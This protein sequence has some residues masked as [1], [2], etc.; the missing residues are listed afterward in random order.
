M[1]KQITFTKDAWDEFLYWQETDK[2]TLKKINSLIKEIF[3]TPFEGTG[4]PE[5]LKDN[6]SGFWSRHIT[7]E[8][9]MVYRYEDGV[10]S[11]IQLKYHY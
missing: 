3:R 11:I 5:P 10:I 1:D 6:L 7:D 4:K 9:R 8:H 2:K